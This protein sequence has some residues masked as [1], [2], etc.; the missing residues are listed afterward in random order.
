MTVYTLLAEFIVKK[1]RSPAFI[2]IPRHRKVRNALAKC[3]EVY[4][5]NAVQLQRTVRLFSFKCYVYP[6]CPVRSVPVVL[7]VAG[8]VVLFNMRDCVQVMELFVQLSS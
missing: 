8:I 2:D 1:R 4:T 6:A 7:R 5:F 3:I